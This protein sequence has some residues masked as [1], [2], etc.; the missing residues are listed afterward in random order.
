MSTENLSEVMKSLYGPTAT[1][2]MGGA[3]KS[4]I[5]R[6]KGGATY[7]ETAYPEYITNADFQLFIKSFYLIKRICHS[8][9]ASVYVIPPS[10]ELKSMISDFEKTLKDNKITPG[11]VEAI[12]YATMNDLPFKKCIFSVFADAD[13]A[14]YKL[15]KEAPYKE[16]GTV[17]RTNL[18]SEQYYFKYVNETEIKICPEEKSDSGSTT[19]KL[20]AKCING[21]YVFQGSIPKAK[22]TY[23]KKI[24]NSLIGGS[25]KADSLIKFNHFKN[26]LNKYGEQGAERFIAGCVKANQANIKNYAKLFS[27][28]LLHS[29]FRMCFNSSIPESFEDVNAKEARTITKQLIKMFK[30]IDNVP[31]TMKFMNMFKGIYAKTV[32]MNMT[33]KESSKEYIN[34]LNKV[35]SKIGKDMLYADIATNIYRSHNYDSLQDIYNLV[36]NTESV[37]KDLYGDSSASVHLEFSDSSTNVFKT[38]KLCNYV[39]QALLI[40]PLVGVNAKSYYPQLQSIDVSKKSYSKMNMYGGYFENVYSL[41]SD[42]NQNEESDENVEVNEEI[43]EINNVDEIEEVEEKKDE[44]E[45][46][47]KKKKKIEEGEGNAEEKKDEE[48]EVDINN[49]I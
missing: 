48:V 4:K 8:Y 42:E 40:A 32:A 23:E 13:S 39:N 17:K 37:D 7:E 12:Q 30:P 16:F 44:D 43:N 20:I 5:K 35:Y 28:D 27:G 15:D 46:E 14:H 47:E 3:K 25:L 11:S 2:M 26:Y 45:D 36:E 22:Q 38:S 18:L 41:E 9:A 49:Y 19:V 6:T 29:A 33:P 1:Q 24:K 21:I 10:S 31:D 34:Q